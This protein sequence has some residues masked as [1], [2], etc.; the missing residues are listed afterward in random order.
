MSLM[1]FDS[2]TFRELAGLTLA[3][4]ALVA[5]G[6]GTQSSIAG[7]AAVGSRVPDDAAT[8]IFAGGCFWCMEPAFEK[9]DGVYTV[10]SGYSGGPEKDPTYQ[11]V[12]S[13][14][15]GHAEVVQVRFDASRVGYE[16]LLD[17]YWR[18]IDPTDPGGQFADRGTQYRTAVF[19]LDEEQRRLAEASRN[20]LAASGPFD[21]PIVTEIVEAGAFY[22]AEAYHQDYYKKNPTHYKAYRRGS[23]REGFLHEV[24]G[25]E[26]SE[27]NAKDSKPERQSDQAELRRRL[28]PLQYHVTQ[29]D[30]T[31]PSFDN[32]YWDNKKQ[33]IY[34]DVVSGE[35][36]FSSTDKYRSGTGWPSFTRP[37]DPDNIVEHE[38]RELL[39]TRTEVRSADADSHL[40]HLFPDGPEPTGQR[41]CINSAA[42]RFIPKEDLEKE[43]Y[44]K[45]LRLFD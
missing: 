36:L 14:E 19:W 6:C 4:L 35:P 10:V 22:P 27:I 28:T 9:L 38:D 17:V 12:S 3:L 2:M 20:E 33:G 45:Y 7:Q 15:T 37:I 44:G 30:G 23:G 26:M 5:T 32:E 40:G 29:E 41:Y 21:R 11:Q 39:M 1:R 25:D 43:G 24:W 34:V 16:Q 42:L 18:Q 8:A 31:E 13:G